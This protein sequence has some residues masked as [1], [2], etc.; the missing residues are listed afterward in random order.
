MRE[1]TLIMTDDLQTRS[2]QV[3]GRSLSRRLAREAN[4][5][6]NCCCD[7]YAL[8]GESGIEAVAGGLVRCFRTTSQHKPFSKLT[9]LI[10][11]GVRMSRKENKKP[12]ALLGCSRRTR[13][14]QGT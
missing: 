14:A 9:A 6:H 7:L 10:N 4:E 11:H 13:L 2:M 3:L 12:K 5:V 1:I 8:T